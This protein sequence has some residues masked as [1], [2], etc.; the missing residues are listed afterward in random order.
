MARTFVGRSSEELYNSELHKLFEVMQHIIDQP[1][2]PTMGPI[3]GRNGALWLDRTSGGDLK[4]KNNDTWE[5]VFNDKFRMIC[6]I[7][8]PEE[9]SIPVSGQ[10]WLNDGILMY[11]SGSEWLPV[12]SVNVAA[13]FNLSAFEQFLIISPVPAAGKL[14]VDE[15]NVNAGKIQKLYKE[16]EFL[17]TDILTTY[18]LTTGTYY[19]DTSSINVYVEGLKLPKSHF[20][21]IDETSIRIIKDPLDRQPTAPNAKTLVVIEYLNKASY[22]SVDFSTPIVLEPSDT[23]TQFLLPS[24]E[25]DRFFIDGM[26]TDDYKEISDVAIEYPTAG[27]QGKFASAIHVNPKKLTNVRK[28]LFKIDKLNPIIPVTETHTEYYGIKNGI[29]KF[30][31]KAKNNSEYVSIAQGIKLLPETAAKYDFI[32]TIT[33]EF[34]NVKGTGSMQKGKV[35]LSETTSIYIGEISDPLCVFV[36][37]LYLDED[38]LNYVYEDGFLK[39]KL[40]TKMDVGV[41]AF[42]KKEVGTIASLNE[43]QQGIITIN[44][45]YNRLLV[46]VYG[47]NL[48]WSLAD[49]EFDSLDDSIIY[50]NKAKEGMR[51]AIVETK[52]ADP[53][54]EMF[55]KS[56]V[57]Q[58]DPY[59]QDC[60]IA[61]EENE[62]AD[63]EGVILFVNGLLMMK[64]DV[65]I[66]TANN[67]IDIYGG[68]E[69]GL[70]YVLLK[71]PFGRFIFSDYVSFNTLPLKQRADATLVYIENQLA[72]DAKAVYT[73][74][75][76]EKGMPGEI[77][78]LLLNDSSDWY[79]YHAVNGWTQVI[80]ELEIETLENSAASYVADDYTINILQ[81]FGKKDCVYYAYQYANS[82]EQPLLRGV[83]KT[84]EGKE[85][86]RTA[87]NHVFPANK[88]ALSIWQ[89]GLRQYPDTTGDP[90]NFNGY[91]E[92]GNSKFK[93]PNPIDGIMFYVVE[94]PEGSEVKSCERQV[95]TKDDVIEGT[96]N[97]FK[98]NIPLWPG[99]IRVFVSGLRQPESAFKVIDNY[100][101]MIKD[102]VLIYPS[103]FP[104]ESVELEDGSFVDIE[105]KHPDS[106]LIEVRQD[107]ALKEI[108][109]PIRYSGQNE[110]SVAPR[111]PDDITKGGDGLPESIL[112]SKD[113]IM[114]YINGM[115]YGKDYRIDEDQGKIIL[116]NDTITNTLG[117]DPI[118]EYFKANPD[119]YDEWR[120]Q[121]GGKEY[122]AKPIIDTITFEWR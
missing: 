89:N 76:P 94:K 95:L 53:E 28:R 23:N 15:N 93:V 114:I 78:Q 74:R 62:L 66:D 82:V 6:E 100:Q 79:Y 119:K 92:L 8:S 11:F 83:I 117:K 24:V 106:I 57:I 33:Y 70:E 112:T 90:E 9:P 13:E 68:F 121:N 35:S 49:Y 19:L 38:P 97:I 80:D 14:V 4:F 63:D 61:L 72:T 39:L 32:E 52:V 42:P 59:T 71:D 18:T 45:T 29:G 31:L 34:K 30:L 108:T 54:E 48:D 7:L 12:K 22:D 75:L 56:G 46:F 43:K 65:T 16:E 37:G 1:S 110:W 103:N 104:T 2:D 109:L 85:E 87:F 26:H 67:R 96:K 101:I 88:N 86:Y 118:D 3:T 47:E 122:T 40:E 107:Y 21:E 115:A 73:S 25:L 111:N 10:L 60:F 98:T 102:D 64:K 20:E 27:L 44:N 81:N 105:R 120:I 55:Y 36:Q 99:N 5:T 116:T 91:F 51:Y 41:I 84:L 69:E 50:I 17:V 58:K 77:K 113:F